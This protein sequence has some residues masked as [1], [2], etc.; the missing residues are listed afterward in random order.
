MILTLDLVCKKINLAYEPQGNSLKL[1]IF[2]HAIDL[3][4]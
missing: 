4:R 3:Q 2:K 1:S